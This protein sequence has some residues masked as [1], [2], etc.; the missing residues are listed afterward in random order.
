MSAGVGHTQIFRYDDKKKK[1]NDWVQLGSD[2]PGDVN[3]DRFGSAI[4]LDA[5]GETL[6][7]VVP[8]HTKN[9]NDVRV[10]R[11][12]KVSKEWAQLGLDM[13]YSGNG[14]SVALSSDGQ[15]VVVPMKDGHVR[16]YQLPLSCAE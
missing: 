6:A 1:K 5:T 13:E 9:D 3:G 10:L 2:L 12:D 4:S 16:A 7:M 8:D 11:F 14:G 15:S